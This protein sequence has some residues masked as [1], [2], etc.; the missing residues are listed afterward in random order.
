M[1]VAGNERFRSDRGTSW[2]GTCS[3]VGLYTGK[4]LNEGDL[5]EEQVETVGVLKNRIR[6]QK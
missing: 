1:A 6:M 2:H 3:G 4:Y 5:V